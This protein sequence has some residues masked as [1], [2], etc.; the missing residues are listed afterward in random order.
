MCLWADAAAIICFVSG[1]PTN[2]DTTAQDQEQDSSLKISR[3]DKKTQYA[4]LQSICTQVYNII[5]LGADSAAAAP[6]IVLALKK[7]RFVRD[8]SLA[9]ILIYRYLYFTYNK[10]ALPPTIVICR[11]TIMNARRDVFASFDIHIPTN[12]YI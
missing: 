6:Q 7:P 10:Y 3:A 8:P 11:N 1:Y 4:L 9:S 2:A 12:C 5:W